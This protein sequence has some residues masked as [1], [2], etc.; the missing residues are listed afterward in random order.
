MATTDA[1]DRM[2]LIANGIAQILDTMAI[3]TPG[4]GLTF[5]SPEWPG[6]LPGYMIE[7]GGWEEIGPTAE[8]RTG[9]VRPD[10]KTRFELTLVLAV[11]FDNPKVSQ[12]KLRLY[13]SQVRNA[14]RANPTLN[15]ACLASIPKKGTQARTLGQT[16]PVLEMHIEF[17][18]DWAGTW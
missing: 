11:R 3:F 12:E 18:A 14:L 16:N 10:S 7:T 1:G 9:A 8:P 2:S 17:L 13:T 5:A 15:G 6:A 4:S